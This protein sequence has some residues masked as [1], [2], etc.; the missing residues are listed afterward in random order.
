MGRLFPSDPN[1]ISIR[2]TYFQT[3]KQYKNIIKLKKR[4]SKEE[5]LKLLASIGN[6]DIKQKWKI[7][8]PITDA[9]SNKED[10]AKEIDLKRWKDYFQNLYN[11]NETNDNLPDSFDHKG[12]QNRIDRA[13]F[14]KNKKSLNCPFTKKEILSCKEKRKSSKALGVAM[15]KNEVLKICFDNK[16]FLESLQVL[17]NNIFY[18]GKYPT[19]WKTELTRPIHKNEETYLEKNYRGISLTS[20]LG[21]VLTIY[22]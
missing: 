8:K 10:P 9:D 5:K 11:C 22:C 18:D 13:D 4:N 1:N 2:N 7:I 15:I 17:F 12:N 6:N 20:C 19:S 16:G 3:K 21:N 14:E